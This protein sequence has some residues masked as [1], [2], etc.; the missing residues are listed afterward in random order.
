MKKLLYLSAII[1]FIGT[2]NIYAQKKA[3][4]KFDK[5]EHDFGQIKEE[6]GKVQCTFTFTNIG[7]DTLKIVSVKPSGNISVE[8]TQTGVLPKKTGTI[9]AVFNP[10][11]RP[12]TFKKIIT[13]TTNDSTQQMINLVVKADV[14]PKPKGISD[15]Y[16]GVIGN[17]RLES[18]KVVFGKTKNP[19]IQNDTLKV[20]NA[21]NQPMTIGFKDMAA[22]I[23]AKAV[24]ETLEPNKEGL[25]IINYD[26]AKRMVQGL[27]FD[28]ITLLTNDMLQSKKTISLVVKGDVIPK[29]KGI[30]DMYPV[31][32]GNLRL[33]SI[34]VNFGKIKNTE[35]HKDTLKVFNIWNKP[36]TL[37]FKK[38]I[39]AY[40]TAKAVP[41]TLEPNK[42]GLII[43]DYDATKRNEWGF[44]SDS[45]M[46][47]TNDGLQSEKNIGLS[48]NI[49]E[50]FS[51]LTPEQLA[52]AP[53]IKFDNI[54]FNFGTAKQGERVKCNFVFRNEG[55]NDLI[56]RNVSSSCQLTSANPEKTNLKKGEESKFIVT[57]DK[58]LKEGYQNKII[59][60]ITNDPENSNLNLKILGTIEKTVPG[61]TPKIDSNVHTCD[62]CSKPAIGFCDIR[63]IWVCEAHRNF[64]DYKGQKIKCPK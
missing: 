25:I 19:G 43:L 40:I 18:T 22:Y 1:A 14:I 33:E 9:N 63:R 56:I 55:D 16:P 21:W 24:P 32:V 10:Q 5:T 41:E 59:T 17:L 2:G 15:I 48:M 50:D 37:G 49:C 42:E 31:V 53:K 46:L 39:A 44:V 52:A 26:A 20:I 58:S 13:V 6:A 23:T 30:P 28:S 34:K 38:D 36:M 57:F 8:W 12:G 54:T 51:K 45:I 3:V 62:F 29:P 60:V 64:T 47:I 11:N 61:V 27:V 4:I 7:N 35:I